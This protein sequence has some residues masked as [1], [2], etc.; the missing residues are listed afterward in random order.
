[1]HGDI[2]DGNDG[3]AEPGAD[4]KGTVGGDAGAGMDKVRRT[5]KNLPQSLRI[6]QYGLKV[7]RTPPSM[8]AEWW[9]VM[10]LALPLE[11]EWHLSQEGQGE[12]S[13]LDKR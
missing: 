5:V 10:D 4:G 13:G 12:S 9:T 6:K 7:S 1:M 11:T 2:M 8:A 3:S